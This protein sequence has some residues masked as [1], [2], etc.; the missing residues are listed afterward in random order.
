MKKLALGALFVGLTA[1]GGGS[2]NNNVVIVDGSTVDGM[3]V[4]N[5]LTQTGCNAGE[6]CTWINDQDNPPVGH[7]GC[8]PAGTVAIGSACT[9]GPA[10]PMGYDNCAKGGVCLGGECK[11]ICDHQGGAPTCDQNHSCTRYADFFVSGGNTVAGVCDPSCDPLTQNLKIGTAPANLACGS[12]MPTAPTKGCYGYDSYSCAPVSTATLTL[13]DRTEPRTNGAGNPYLNGCAPGFIPL[14]F[15]GT[16]SMKTLCSGFCAALEADNRDAAHI[17][18]VKGDATALG[19]LPAD[20][21]PVVNKSTCAANQ[22]GSAGNSHCKFLWPF[23]VENNMLPMQ[24][25]EGPYLDTLG[26]CM[27]IDQFNY[28]N[29]M[30]PATP[31]VN[32]PSCATLPPPTASADD[33]DAGDWFCA[34]VSSLVPPAFNSGSKYPSNPAMR[35]IRLPKREDM[36]L[37]ITRHKLQQQ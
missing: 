15:E 26:V 2:D 8:A 19:K 25:E 23:L 16:G 22:K 32:Y 33:D 37:E 20:P 35:D 1:C 30:D 18:A 4:C 28:D 31:N 13:T 11:Q 29:D 14:F 36:Q 7:V 34:K 17:A 27:L 12:P 21:A 3:T 6:M 10:G 24:F 9:E 5:P